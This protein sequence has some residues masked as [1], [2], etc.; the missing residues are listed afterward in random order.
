MSSQD[1]QLR[2]PENTEKMA[3]AKSRRHET[4][5]PQFDSRFGDLFLYDSKFN[6]S[7]SFQHRRIITVRK[8]M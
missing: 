2:D 6:E 3:D 8:L 7:V 1:Y 4:E 5:G